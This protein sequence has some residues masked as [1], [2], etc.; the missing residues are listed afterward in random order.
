MRIRFAAE[1]ICAAAEGLG[2]GQQL[3]VDLEPDDRL[4]PVQHFRR[5]ARRHNRHYF[6]F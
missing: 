4:I 1:F 5:N 3:Y 6:R 2:I